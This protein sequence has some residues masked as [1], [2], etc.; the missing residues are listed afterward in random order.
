MNVAIY[1]L[2]DPR[3]GHLRYI[4]KSVNCRERL[5]RHIREARRGS[6]VHCKRWIAGI[7]AAGAC[8]EMDVLE[9]VDDAAAND[10][11]RFWIAAMRLA[12]AAL[13]NLTDGGDGQSSSY[14]A[15]AETKRKMSLATKGKKLS[16]E[17][18]LAIAAK[19]GGPELRERKRVLMAE[20]AATGHPAI[21]NFMKGRAGL[22]NSEEHRRKQREWWTPERR[23]A[24]AEQTRLR[25]AK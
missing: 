3:T 18:R 15:S 25:Q 10:A 5:A 22:K 8:P 7:L 4:G 9:V 6:T 11:E 1:G 16:P 23:A 24:R 14:R 2:F 13:T 12:G 17:H 21:A 19:L 20:R